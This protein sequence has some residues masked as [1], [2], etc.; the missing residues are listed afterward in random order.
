MD[1]LIEAFESYQ[2]AKNNYQ[3]ACK[4]CEYDRDYFLYDEKM[5]VES[6]KESLSKCFEKLVLDTIKKATEV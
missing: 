4:H 6:T 2:E 1:D 3:E 5:Q